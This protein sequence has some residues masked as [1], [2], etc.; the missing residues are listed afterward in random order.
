MSVC[1]IMW[2]IAVSVLLH[3]C[4]GLYGS[5]NTPGRICRTVVCGQSKVDVCRVLY[6]LTYFIRCKDL[7]RESAGEEDLDGFHR[8]RVGAVST[9]ESPFSP[10]YVSDVTN[11]DGRERRH[12]STR[13]SLS[14]LPCHSELSGGYC[15][16]EKCVLPECSTPERNVDSSKP[17]SNGDLSRQNSSEECRSRVSSDS[18]MSGMDRTGLQYSRWVVV[19]STGPC[20]FEYIQQTSHH[21]YLNR[22]EYHGLPHWD[23]QVQL[24][25]IAF[26][27]SL[28]T[29]A[30]ASHG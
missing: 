6:I 22:M 26:Q 5:M 25:V 28:C 8:P 19:N 20:L 7:V 4:R 2:S 18:G 15:D 1:M 30:I 3:C 13:S 16:F 14:D 12:P 11:F 23:L 21:E 27:T 24:F 29:S 9:S 10:R 17:R